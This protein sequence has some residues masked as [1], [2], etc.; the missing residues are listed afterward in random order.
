MGTASISETLKKH[1]DSLLSLP[2]VSGIGEGIFQGSP[3]IKIYVE[4]QTKELKEKIPLKLEGF[5]VLIVETG[6]F[7]AYS[8]EQY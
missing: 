3:C 5:P 6:T 1:S 2:G 4:T 7:S 8:K